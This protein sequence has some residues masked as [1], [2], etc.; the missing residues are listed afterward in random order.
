MTHIA[1]VVA[2]WRACLADTARLDIDPK[3][4]KRAYEVSTAAVKAGRL[5][6]T[7]TS[8][9]V[10]AFREATT[11]P[12]GKAP[13][14]VLHDEDRR[15]RVLICPV[16]ARPRSHHTVYTAGK[17]TALTPVWIPAYLSPDGALSPADNDLPW[18]PRNLLEPVFQAAE[19]IGEVEAM[20]RFMTRH[21][22]LHNAEHPDQPPRWSDV[23][24]YSNNMLQAVA[25]QTL[26]HF[27]RE[28]YETAQVTHLLLDVDVRSRAGY[29]IRLYDTILRRLA[30]KPAAP[31]TLLPSDPCPTTRPRLP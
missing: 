4:L 12:Q 27:A 6:I 7:I 29:I 31:P 10:E 28:G 15:V 16:V 23:W 5:P 2:Y 3:R 20:D 22:S 13:Q 17:D 21:P 30:E 8:N 11:S 18:I 19:T 25:Q 1:N 14:A 9:I 26:E 24:Q